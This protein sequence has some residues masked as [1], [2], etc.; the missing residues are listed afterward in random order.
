MFINLAFRLLGVDAKLVLELIFVI[1]FAS[2]LEEL[3]LT[4]ANEL[5]VFAPPSTE[6]KLI[7]VDLLNREDIVQLC[8]QN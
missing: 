2:R 5:A 3:E 1:L 7:P 8:L 6:A 4:E